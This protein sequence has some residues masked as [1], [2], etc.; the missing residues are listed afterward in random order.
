MA[1]SPIIEQTG[2]V[3]YRA[4]A[5]R[6]LVLR[7]KN[8]DLDA[9]RRQVVK[10]Y[11]TRHLFTHRNPALIVNTALS[12]GYDLWRKLRP[13]P[14][15]PDFHKLESIEGPHPLP[16]LDADIFVH[17]SAE[18]ADIC[19]QLARSLINGWDDV[20]VLDERMC[21]THMEGRDL[22]GFVEA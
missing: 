11:E 12:F 16:A 20:E 6:F 22:T 14:A 3:A 4:N 1:T 15:V 2:V 7:L 8:K 9:L 17:L 21:F 18:N 13:D 5:A 19:F 10:F